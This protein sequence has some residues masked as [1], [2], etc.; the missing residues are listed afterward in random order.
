MAV[1]TPHDAVHFVE[2]CD[3][4]I[5]P[6]DL[7][8]DGMEREIHVTIAYG[9]TVSPQDVIDALAGTEPLSMTLGEISKFDTSPEHDVIKVDVQSSG[10]EDLHYFLRELFGEEGLSVSFPVYHPHLTLAYVKK[11]SCD[12]LIGHGKFSGSTYVFNSLVYSEPDSTRKHAVPLKK[13]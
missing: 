3:A 10:F 2:W 9:F 13:N 6:S 11:G 12:D 4:N 7:T 1:L 5:H 8:G